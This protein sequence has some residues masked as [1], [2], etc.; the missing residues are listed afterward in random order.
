MTEK[1]I[2]QLITR[3]ETDSD[4]VLRL[5]AEH[6]ADLHQWCVRRRRMHRL[7]TDAVIA[8]SVI[9]FVVITAL[10]D[11]DGHYISDAQARTETI[12]NID[13]TLLASI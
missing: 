11:T 7:V 8:A 4:R 5:A 10:P 2:L 9:A 3:P 1:E 6:N 12:N 13:Q